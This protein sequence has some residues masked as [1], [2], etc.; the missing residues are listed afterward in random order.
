MLFINGKQTKLKI[1]D[2]LIVR[3]TENVIQFTRKSSR[4]LNQFD[5]DKTIIDPALCSSED[6][7]LNMAR[8]IAM[9]HGFGVQIVPNSHQANGFFKFKFTRVN[10]PQKAIVSETPAGIQ[11]VIRVRKRKPRPNPTN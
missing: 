9:T 1:G 7:C 4:L 5:D 3:Q 2:E 10:R 11:V 6:S 8:I